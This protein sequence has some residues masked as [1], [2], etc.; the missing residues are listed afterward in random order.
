M[1]KH[2]F[3]LIFLM[4]AIVSARIIPHPLFTDNMVLQQKEKVLIYGESDSFSTISINPSWTNQVFSGKPDKDGKW[5]IAVRTPAAGGPYSVIIRNNHEEI[6]LSNVMIGEVWICSGQSNMQV[7]MSELTK[8]QKIVDSDEAIATSSDYPISIYTVQRQLSLEPLEK[9][10]GAWEPMTSEVTARSSAIAFFF[11]RKL[12]QELGVPVGLIVNAWSGSIVEAWMTRQDLSKYR[13]YLDMDNLSVEDSK[14]HFRP[15]MIHNGMMNPLV[16]YKAK[17][18]LWYQGESNADYLDCYAQKMRDMVKR[19]RTLWKDPKMAFYYVQIAP[20]TNS[21]KSGRMEIREAQHKAMYLIPYSQMISTVDIGGKLLHPLRKE[22][23]GVRLANCALTKSYKKI[24]PYVGPELKTVQYTEANAI[25]TM[26][27][28]G[29]GLYADGKLRGFEIAGGD[30]VFHPAMA[31]IKGKDK[32]VVSS[33]MVRN[34]KNVR[35]AYRYCLDGNV[36][37]SYGLPPFPFTT[38]NQLTM[39]AQLPAIIRGCRENLSDSLTK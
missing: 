5:S 21:H 25:L 29:A 34:P 22:E 2:L 3:L 20:I 36:W 31:Y 28:V 10:K 27:N 24:V 32:I 30:G 17:G 18:F 9:C 33:S 14:P 6:V 26:D 1:K 13:D 15:L 8:G 38:E 35:F 16:G 19:W 23:V 37:N 4:P 39:K 12:T 11:A 7:I